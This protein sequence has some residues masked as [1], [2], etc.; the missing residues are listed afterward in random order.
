MLHILD[1]FFHIFHL[2]TIIINVTFWMT[3]RTLRIAQITLALTLLSWIGLGFIYGFGYCF[4]TDWHWQIK[5]KL[6]ES[7]L[8]SS[9][10]KFIVDRT[11]GVNSEP[12]TVNTFTWIVLAISLV[13]CL[14]QTL[15]KR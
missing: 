2:S 12:D 15:R 11:F 9:Y 4:L 7:D 14:V 6:G 3:F 5:E 13:G 10:I 1:L 8:P